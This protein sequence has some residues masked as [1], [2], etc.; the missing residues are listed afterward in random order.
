[1]A[2]I[3]K[4]MDRNASM[5]AMRGFYVT[6]MKKDERTGHYFGVATWISKDHP[7]PGSRVVKTPEPVQTVDLEDHSKSEHFPV[8]L[9]EHVSEKAA[10]IEDSRSEFNQT[11]ERLR[12][13]RRPSKSTFFDPYDPYEL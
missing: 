5:S 12:V 6:R 7:L 4:S 10:Q 2:E 9:E 8:K 13:E 11:V 1:L 3:F